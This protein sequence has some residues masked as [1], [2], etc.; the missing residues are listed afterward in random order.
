MDSGKRERIL[1]ACVTFETV[2]V[3]D[4]IEYYESTK[5][6]LI[7]YS[8]PNSKYGGIYV[9]FYEEICNHIEQY[10]KSTEI[11]EH[12]AKV[13][14]FSI[15]MKTVH[16]ILEKERCRSK[17]S[18]I[19]I[20]ISAGTSEYIAAAVI[21][22][23][24]FPG[25]IPFSVSTEEYLID[26]SNYYDKESGKPIG[27]SKTVKPPKIVSKFKIESPDRNLVL[28]LKVLDMMNKNNNLPKG[29]D[30]IK[31]LKKN[32]LWYR[33]EFPENIAKRSESVYYQRDFINK[34][35]DNEWIY[36]DKF[37]KRYFVTEKGLAILDI[38][39]TECEITI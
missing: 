35:L 5:V 36:R 13:T 19:F 31:V 1:I 23:M 6:H 3:T 28:G 33:G 8:D 34:W 21:A 4:P 14:D 37:V 27:I 18:D 15:M 25:V 11:V 16:S 39:Y 7:R 12:I 32:G 26:A 9:D 20:N 30:I 24:M 29:T 17:T 22:S 38:F 2:K 10:S